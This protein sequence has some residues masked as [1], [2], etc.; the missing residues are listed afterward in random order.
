M[1]GIKSLDDLK[2][3]RD[4][5]RESVMVRDTSGTEKKTRL[6]VGMATCGIA[7][8]SRETLTAI[9]DEISKQGIANATVV[10]SGCMGYCYAEPTVEV[11][12]PGR[13]PV[14]Y[15]NINA[16]RGRELIRKHIKGGEVQKDW[17]IKR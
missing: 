10:Q 4:K 14:L 1:S 12:E 17:I 9:I 8:G 16:E 15:G 6:A 5:Y 13:E 3:L 2:A 11:R 7:S